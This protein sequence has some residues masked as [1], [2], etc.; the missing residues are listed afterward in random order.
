M[1][2]QHWLQT[3]VVAGLLT[4][5]PV[6]AQ[7]TLPNSIE[8]FIQGGTQAALDLNETSTN[9]LFVKYGASPFSSARKSYFKFDFA[10]QT[11]N[12]N[13]LLKLK[14]STFTNNRRQHVQVWTL[15][16][17]YPGFTSPVLTW[18]G[19]QANETNGNGL[20]TSGALTATV[21]ADF[22]SPNAA[23]QNAIVAIPPPW[24]D[25]II[26]GKIFLVLATVNDLTNDN[27]GTRITLNST[28]LEF[29]SIISG[30]PPTISSISNLTTT[31][32]QNSATNSFTVGDVEDGPNALAPVATSSNE[33][34]VP[35]A[36]VF[37]EGTGAN[38]TVYVIG[39]AAGTATITVTVTDSSGNTADRLFTVTVLPLNFAPIVS[40]PAPTNTPLNTPVTVSFTTS[41][42]ETPATNL[43]VTGEVAAYSTAI[44][45][46]VT[47]GSDA[48][49]TNRTVTVTPV[50]GANGVGVVK[51]SVND[52]E[53]NSTSVSFAVMVLAAPNVVFND[54]FDYPAAQIGL[55][56]GS[57]NLWARRSVAA[58]AVNFSTQNGAAYIRPKSNADDGAALLAGG[59]Y[60]PASRAVLYTKCTVTW[61]DVGAELATNSTGGFLNLSQTASST[62][63]QVADV[64]TLTNSAPDGNFNLGL[65]DLAGVVQPNTNVA[66]PILGGPYTIVTRYDV[67]AAKSTLWVNATTEADPFVSVSDRATPVSINYVGLRQDLGM[68]YIYSDDLQV[69]VA[70]TPLITSATLPTGGTVDIF[71]AAGATDAI[72]N[73]GVDSASAVTGPYGNVAATITSLGGGNFKATVPTVSAAQGYYRVKRLPVT[74]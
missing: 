40:T 69:I 26:N 52:P 62:S 53:G 29:T 65:N 9:Y 27:N 41:D 45:S 46:D 39:A 37:F 60:T 17:D 56:P 1:K 67:A 57:A 6:T 63:I 44:L 35:S 68:G 16:Q 47:F 2:T 43:V 22:I 8:A 59:P 36:N 12:T 21:R 11:P 58:G 38:R 28:A 31:A 5:L 71:F 15:N 13:A 70:I 42:T 51:I 23:S 25:A 19:A 48:S 73:F 61:I 10:G 32:T 24:G 30:L 3:L 72:G 7:V 54:H 66:I 14:F 55:F 64:A 33:A 4:T 49:G 20:L 50:N 18:N 34:I 74:F